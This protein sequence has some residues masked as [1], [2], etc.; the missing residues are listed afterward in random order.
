MAWKI[1]AEGGKII[2]NFPRNLI[3]SVY[4]ACCV[5]SNDDNFIYF[6]FR[7]KIFISGVIDTDALWWKINKLNLQIN[8]HFF[9]ISWGKIPSS[10]CYTS[11]SLF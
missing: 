7:Q 5:P 2:F 9:F 10:S 4:G 1:M 8:K 3:D 11:S 6:F